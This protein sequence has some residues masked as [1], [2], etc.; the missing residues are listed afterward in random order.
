[1]GKSIGKTK[2]PMN[3][4]KIFRVMLTMVF[5]ISAVFLIKNL[6]SKS[7]TAA[8]AVGACIIAFAVMATVMKVLKIRKN[9]QKFG[10][11]IC[12]MLLVFVIS[13]FSGNYYSDDFC[14]YLAVIGL[15]G[16]Y[17]QPKITIVQ[18]VLGD[19]FLILQYVINPGKADPLSQ[20]IMCMVCFTV[21]A[22]VVYL[23]IKRGQAFIELGRNRAEEAEQLI[24]S[25]KQIG[26]ELQENYDKSSERI[27]NL[28]NANRMLE[29]S[30]NEITQGSINITL[31][32]REVEE[33]CDDVHERMK[34]TESGMGSLNEEV[35]GVESSL[36]DNREHMTAMS[37]QMGSVKSAIESANEVFNLLEA[38]IKEIYAVTEQLNKI[39]ASTNMLALNASIEAARAGHS[40]AGFAVV[41]TKVQA[42]AVDSNRCSG[43]VADVVKAMQQRIEDTVT[44]LA[45]STAAID[46]SM[47]AMSELEDSFDKL[48]ARFEGL[49]DNIEEQN[50]NIAQMDEIFGELKVKINGMS[51]YSEENQRSVENMTEAMN[52]YRDSMGQVVDD[53]KQIQELSASMLDVTQESEGFDEE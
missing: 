29:S 5:L 38:Q 41:A 16:L 14:L 26:G 11:S 44:E 42:L 40:G 33:V 31:E 39:A 53:A 43:E 36:A 28:Q 20:F 9:I 6:I 8:L 4:N 34:I 48:T 22:F 52:V 17:L 19:I 49:Y 7:W 10:I 45:E 32:A 3:D 1:M 24:D 27:D 25:M 23:T 2:S 50:N 51:E 35:R 30:A 37:E 21:A 18:M 13:L 47:R 46:D 15:S 12:M